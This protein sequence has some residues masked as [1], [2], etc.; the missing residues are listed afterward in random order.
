MKTVLI[1]LLILLNA[2]LVFAQD[3]T[4]MIMDKSQNF[5]KT[6]DVAPDFSLTDQNGK[7]V[8]LSEAVKSAPVV[9]VFY[10][11]YWCPFCAHQL[12][13]LRGLLKSNEKTQLFAVSIDPA[14]KSLELIKK[15][16]SDGKGNINYLLLSD[17]DAK[18][19]DTYKL[20]DD[21][22]AGKDVDGIPFPT[23]YVINKD[24][25]VVWAKIEKDYKLRPTNDE[26][27]AEIEKLK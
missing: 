22:Y 5:I 16:E 9:L 1:G 8:K 10:R 7:T 19:I 13:D 25:Q 11:G 6:G 27:R 15:I 21:R 20:R 23:V 24:R 26:I 18:T 14:A 2:A 17:P 12:S 3:S 4:S